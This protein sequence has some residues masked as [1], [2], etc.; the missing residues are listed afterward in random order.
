MEHAI[1][2]L[3][4][5]PI[6][7]FLHRYLINQFQVYNL[8]VLSNKTIHLTFE[9]VDLFFT[10]LYNK[11][12]YIKYMT[13]GNID[14]FLI[15]GDNAIHK[16]KL[17]KKQIRSN[18]GVT[19]FDLQNLVHS[20]DEGLEYYLQF[21]CLF[22]E[23]NVKNHS[24][25]ADAA[26]DSKAFGKDSFLT[27]AVNKHESKTI[28]IEYYGFKKDLIYRNIPLGV[29][30]Y[31]NTLQPIY[32]N[33][34]FS[35]VNETVEKGGIVALMAMPIVQYTDEFI[36][37]LSSIGI[38]AA[39]VFDKRFTLEESKNL[40]DYLNKYDI[41]PLGGSFN[42]YTPFEISISENTYNRFK[43]RMKQYED[44]YDCC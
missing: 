19:R 43:D 21:C 28:Q 37:D 32:S 40:Q 42:S 34:L 31:F 10:T 18:Y 33:D 8:T 4:P 13:S 2:L 29:V 38:K 44:R 3:K 17:I 25:F 6:I 9:Q 36:K 35:V 1:I 7:E 11:R 30:S 15:K 16:A 26:M 5:S 41:V 39:F 12:D 24:G 22:P 20:S 27:F 14:V 23:R